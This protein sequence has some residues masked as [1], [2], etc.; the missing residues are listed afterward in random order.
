LKLDHI[1]RILHEHQPQ[2]EKEHKDVTLI[3]ELAKAHP[4]LLE[5]SCRPG[6]VTGSALVIDP[7]LG[8]VLLHYHKRLVRWL[9]FG[10][11]ADGERDPAS[12][13]LREATEESGLEGLAFF[14]ESRCPRPMDIDVHRIPAVP[15]EPAHLHLDFRYVLALGTNRGLRP[16]A[17]ESRRFAWHSFEEVALMTDRIDPALRRLVAKA[18]ALGNQRHAR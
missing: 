11:H 7:R 8:K 6:H 5:R 9:Q 16:G 12:I 17:G 18:A 3:I 13:A 10:G 4:D 14:P 15:G 1:L 2:D